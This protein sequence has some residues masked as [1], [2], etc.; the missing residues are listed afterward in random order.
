MAYCVHT[1]CIENGFKLHFS[2]TYTSS[3]IKIEA[4][5]HICVVIL[6]AKFY[7]TSLLNH[8]HP[9][10]DLCNLR[11]KLGNRSDI[12][13]TASFHRNCNPLPLSTF[14]SNH[15]SEVHI[16]N[17]VGWILSTWDLVHHDRV[18]RNSGTQGSG[19]VTPCPLYLIINF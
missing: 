8:Y 4:C 12:R 15:R 18:L 19:A 3:N 11:G 10:D 17:L 6:F 9:H 1:I 16:Y 13:Q 2:S 14:K 5:K 7:R